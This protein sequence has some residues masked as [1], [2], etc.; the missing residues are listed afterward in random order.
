[1]KIVHLNFR[2]FFSCF[3]FFISFIKKI[4]FRGRQRKSSQSDKDSIPT[5]VTVSKDQVGFKLKLICLFV[6]FDLLIN[7]ASFSLYMKA[8]GKI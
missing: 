7:L 3:S 4:L 2:R 6:F 8:Y 1:M 5:S